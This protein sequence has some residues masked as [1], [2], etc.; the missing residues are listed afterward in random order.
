MDSIQEFKHDREVIGIIGF[1]PKGLY[2]LERLLAFYKQQGFKQKVTIHLFNNNNHFGSGAVYQTDQ[3]SYLLMNYA[4]M[5][6][7]MWP[8]NSPTPIVQN[9]LNFTAWYI[10]RYGGKK[11]IIETT[12]APRRLVGEYLEQGFKALLDNIPKN[13]TIVQ[14]IAE[15]DTIEKIHSQYYLSGTDEAGKRFTVPSKFD[16]LL[17]TTGHQRDYAASG[18]MYHKCSK[19]AYI[20]FVYPVQTNL[21]KIKE[22]ATVAVKGMGLTF[23]DTM[24]ALTEGREGKF[25]KIDN[26]YSYSKSGKEPKVLYPFSRSGLPMIPRAPVVKGEHETGK[27]VYFEKE[28]L[29][30]T[31]N[32]RKKVQVDFKNSLLPAIEKDI[33]FAYY[34][35]LFAIKEESLIFD[36]T[37]TNILDKIDQ[38][39]QRYPKEKR[40]SLE[41]LLNPIPKDEYT[42]EAVIIY[43][44]N[45][46]K[47]IEIYGAQAPIQMAVSV[48]RNIS[49][50]FNELYSFGGLTA[51]SQEDFDTNFAGHFNRV[52]YGAP[53]INMKKL[54]VLADMGMVKFE[55]GKSPAFEIIKTKKTIRLT[56]SDKKLT[57]DCDQL[58]NARIPKTNIM[59][60]KTQLFKKLCRQD[61]AYEFINSTNND[62]YKPGCLVINCYGQL[63]TKNDDVVESITLYGTP[64]EGITFDNDTLSRE[65]N[66]FASHWAKKYAMTNYPTSI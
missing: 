25:I 50:L 57:I 49:P 1:G 28:Y 66:D 47:A 63:M 41:T 38:F 30:Y 48:W 8:K 26:S 45:N 21:S 51:A 9:P 61:L 27:P 22:D 37:Y 46:L 44:K 56:T 20:D 52:A 6:I 39:H 12:N 16:N 31:K 33:Q 34:Q 15:I 17:V 54:V 2:G 60:E 4:N 10:N 14:H 24:L 11:E 43:I 58:I 32:K 55:F 7:D 62:H 53:V 5:Y 42:H 64:T 40:F 29:K 35:K 18:S 36:E 13:I 19:G 23:I 65:R 3:P 59:A